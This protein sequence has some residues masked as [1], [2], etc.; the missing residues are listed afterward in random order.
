[1]TDASHITLLPQLLAHVRAV[2][3]GVRL[4]AARI[5]EQTGAGAAVRRGRSRARPGAVARVGLLPADAV[6]AGLGVPG[7]CRAIRASAPRRLGLREYKAEAHIGIVGGTG[8]QLLEAALR[9]PPHRA[10]RAAGAARASWAWPPSCRR[11]T[12]SPRCRATSARRWPAP[13]GADCLRLP[14]AGAAVHRQAALACAL[15]PRPGQSLVARLVRRAVRGQALE[16]QAA[17]GD[18]NDFRVAPGRQSTD[19][20]PG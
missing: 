16:G 19:W 14:G 18:L 6:S 10:A 17:K 12:W 20:T 7:Q 15:P 2:A 11:P 8:D 13:S 5:D 9:A 3:P 4:E 1:M